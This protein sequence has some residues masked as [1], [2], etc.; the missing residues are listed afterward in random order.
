MAGDL[1]VVRYLRLD[2]DRFKYVAHLV[3]VVPWS[4]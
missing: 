2:L 1:V 3:C 4:A